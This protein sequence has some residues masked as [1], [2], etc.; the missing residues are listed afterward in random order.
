MSGSYPQHNSSYIS[1]EENS[2]NTLTFTE[3][4]HRVNQQMLQHIGMELD[5]LPDF[6]YYDNYIDG[7]STTGMTNIIM[8]DINQMLD[9]LRDIE[10]DD[11][12]QEPP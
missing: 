10:W 7:N 11:S 12:V 9:F 2:N 5:E 4:K 8:E 3:W 1:P 6:P